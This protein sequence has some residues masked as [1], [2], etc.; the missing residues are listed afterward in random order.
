[1]L[2]LLLIVIFFVCFGFLLRE[3]IW[4]N[5]IRLINVVAAALIATNSF[6]SV[7]ILLDSSGDWF[8]S[9]TYAWD[10]LALWGAFALYM[11]VLRGATDYVSKVKVRFRKIH[12]QIG[13]AVLA[14]CIGWTM[15][16]FT[17]MSL[18]TAPL[19]RN[20]MRGSFQP[21]KRM[22]LGLAPDRKWLAFVQGL[23]RKS[24]SSKATAEAIREQPAWTED[25][26]RTFDPLSEFMPKY[27]TRR[28]LLENHMNEPG[29]TSMRIR[30]GTSGQ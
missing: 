13:S 3:G 29:T 6:E 17:T 26:T 30:S 19:S 9:F 4:C 25:Q 10:F 27:A 23:S 16:C 24:F 14:A 2:T 1:M 28:T 15:V 22:F 21:E 12:D 20:F 5:T 18:H 7:A 11:A 8:A